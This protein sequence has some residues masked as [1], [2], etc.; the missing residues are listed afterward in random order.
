MKKEAGIEKMRRVLDALEEVGIPALAS[1]YDGTHRANAIGGLRVYCVPTEAQARHIAEHI[2]K[3]LGEKV[4]PPSSA[5]TAKWFSVAGCN[6]HF[7]V[8]DKPLDDKP[9]CDGCPLKAG[10]ENG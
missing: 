1:P 2:G 9:A 7:E 6:V 10:A 4:T 5:S 8:F 3:A